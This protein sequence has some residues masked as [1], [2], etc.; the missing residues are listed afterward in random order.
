M[1]DVSDTKTPDANT[2]PSIMTYLSAL[3]S[4]GTLVAF[5]YALAS[6]SPLVAMF[7][8][9]SLTPERIDQ[10]VAYAKTFGA[11]AAAISALIG[12]VLP[13]VVA[14]FG[15]LSSTVKKQIARVR[16]LANNPQLANEEAAKALV[17]ATKAVANSDVLQQSASATKA[18]VLATKDL[19]GVQT[20]VATKALSEAV[21]SPS[22]VAAEE[23]VVIPK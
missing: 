4:P 1:V 16:E 15:I 20:I 18:L 21:N 3:F 12:I 9:A 22:V 19:A 14:I 10:I 6:I 11:A 5:R 7:G 8:F 17:D 2:P 13:L 23:H